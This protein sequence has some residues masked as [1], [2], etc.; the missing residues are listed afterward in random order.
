MKFMYSHWK[1]ALVQS[2][3]RKRPWK[4]ARLRGAES[5]RL[6]EP[7]S[8]LEATV[9]IRRSNFCVT[10]SCRRTPSPDIGFLDRP[11]LGDAGVKRRGGAGGAERRWVAYRFEI[12]P[13]NPR[14]DRS[15]AGRRPSSR[16]VRIAP[17]FFRSSPKCG[18]NVRERLKSA[19]DPKQPKFNA[20]ERI[21]DC[22]FDSL[23][24][25]CE[26]GIPMSTAKEQE[27]T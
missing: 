8:K 19:V 10:W 9:E 26:H 6:P 14:H 15:A 16:N 11:A 18:R 23:R 1:S 3:N 2:K 4:Y 5:D 20:V 22:Q 25:L 17:D 21:G 27:G 12:L 13:K 7:P 24:R